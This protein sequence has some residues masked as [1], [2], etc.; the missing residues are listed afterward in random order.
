[1]A[2]VDEIQLYIR[3]GKGGDGVVRWRRE[4]FKPKS[5]PGGGDGGRGA[6]VYIEAVSDLAYLD[7]YRNIKSLIAENGEPGGKMGCEGANGQ[8]LIV[9]LPVGSVVTNRDT[10]EIFSLETVGQRICILRGGRGGFG[11]EHFKSSTNTT[12]Y[13]STPGA[14]GQ[15]GNFYIEVQLFADIGLIGLPSAG[16]STLLNALTKAHSKVGEYHFTTLEPHLGVA[17]AGY[18]LADIPGL[19]EG[20]H[21]GKGLG[22]KFLR[23][24]KRTKA[25]AHVI[26]LES[27]DPM[28][29]YDVVRHELIAYDPSF[30]D[31]K[32]IIV[33]SKSDTHTDDTLLARYVDLF[34]GKIVIT[35]SAY[36]DASLK[37]T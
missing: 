16:K 28:H 19:I 33:L 32:E 27:D 24:I 7:Q 23:H 8:D 14:F 1:M 3:A 5:G 11:N 4:K 20:A 31:K 21:E 35:V 13:E 30:T 2:F 37:K 34:K 36:D 29:D 15:E 17:P 10:K 9:K 22:H 25:L 6:D 18:V 26:S 12:P